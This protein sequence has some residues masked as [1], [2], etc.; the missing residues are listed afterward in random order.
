M[1]IKNWTVTAQSVKKGAAAREVYLNDKNHPNHANT[2]A[3]LNVWGSK[4]HTLNIIKTCENYKMEQAQKRKGGRPPTDSME[5]VFTLPKGI[6][7]DQEQW[8]KMLN[9]IMVDTAKRLDIDPKQLTGITRA[10]VHQQNQDPS[11]K[12]SGDH[13]HV[14]VGKFT[15]DGTYLRDLQ[16]KGVLHTMK[17]G[18]NRAVLREM[19]VSHETYEPIKQYEKVA[20][21]RVP[22]WKVAAGREFDN[23]TQKAQQLTRKSNIQTL[24]NNAVMAD[25]ND[26]RRHLEKLSDKVLN[27]CDKWL[28]AFEIGD[29]V[30][31]NRQYN[32]ISKGI[33]EVNGFAPSK[34]LGLFERNLAEK[35]GKAT[36]KID[37]KSQRDALPKLKTPSI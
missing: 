1:G 33:E 31:M 11:V 7:P 24:K 25:I 12:G 22:Q 35:I 2:E 30:Q 32:R 10:V 16:K 3:Y 18:F 5:F 13:M 27:Q 36:E 15:P 19:G 20:K 17:L 21:R 9:T 8:K 28:E 4:N 29:K 6:R 14:V 37:S 34:E 23:L 26:A